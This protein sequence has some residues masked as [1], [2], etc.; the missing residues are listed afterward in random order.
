MPGFDFSLHNRNLAL[1]AQGVPLPKATS[2]G[3][4]IVGCLYDGGVVIAADTRATSGPIVAD[5]N[6]EKLHYIAPQIWC[7]G[8]GTAADTEFTTALISSNIELHA[9]STGRKPRVATVMTMLK[10]HLFRYQGHI[11]AYLVVAGCDPTGSHLFTVHA[12]GST[13]KLPYVTMGSGSLAAMSVFETQWKSGLNKDDAIK[14]CADAIQAGIWNDLGSGSNVDVCVITAEKTTLLR[15]YITPNTRDQKMRNYKFQRGTTAILNEKIITRQ[16]ISK[17]VTVHELSD[18][19]AG[20]AGE[21]MEV[22]S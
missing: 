13:D 21:K 11:G 2:T 10:Q 8:A 12:H 3:T 6:C 16:D 9:L 17:Y 5:K 20:Q 19:D 4:T 22:D 1:H 7:A 15:N 18:N 14:L